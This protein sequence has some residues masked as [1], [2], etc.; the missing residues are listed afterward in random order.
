MAEFSWLTAL[1][2]AFLTFN[3]GMAVYRSN[4]DAGE[5]V[6]IMIPDWAIKLGVCPPRG[7]QGGRNCDSLRFQ[8]IYVPACEE[9]LVYSELDAK[10][11]ML[12]IMK[13]IQENL[14][15][16]EILHIPSTEYD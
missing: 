8:L 11:W 7:P 3:S 16:A 1:G 12:G 9:Q 15:S 14:Q 6:L 10:V 5:F 2:F 4:G 13:E